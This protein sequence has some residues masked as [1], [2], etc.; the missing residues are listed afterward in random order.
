MMI[1]GMER[2]FT[3]ETVSSHIGPMSTRTCNDI[4]GPCLV[5]QETEIEDFSRKWLIPGYLHLYIV[6]LCVPLREH[7]RATSGTRAA[8]WSPLPY[9]PWSTGT[10]THTHTHTH[11]LTHTQRERER[12]RERERWNVTGK[13]GRS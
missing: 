1:N 12:E 3:M 5:G 2:Y 10:H 8:G 6:T 4:A 7:T 11:T 13:P 9:R